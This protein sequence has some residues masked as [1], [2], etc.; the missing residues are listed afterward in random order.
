MTPALSDIIA[1]ARGKSPADLVLAN[2]R[3][4]N[5]FNGDIENGNVA[6][7]DGKIAGIGDYDKARTVIDLDGRYLAPGLINGHT[8]IESSMLDIGQY[9]NA[10]IPHGTLIVVT[11]LHEIA[12]VSGIAGLRYIINA[13][14]RLPFE[15]FLMAP[16]CVPA[17]QLETSGANIDSTALHNILHWK[18]VIGLGEM[19]NYPGVLSSNKEVLN[20]IS[21]SANKIVD[22]HAPDLNGHDL[23]AYIASGIS[24]DHESTTMAEAREKLARGIYIMIREGSSEKNLEALL[25]LVTDKTYKRCLFVVDDRN[26]SDL[27]HDGDV[28]AVVRKAIHLGLEPVR[29]IQMASINA[30]ERFG[31]KNMGA[32]APGYWADMIVVEDLHKF[33]IGMVFHHGKLVA[34]NG[35]PMFNSPVFKPHYLV[36]SIKVKPFNIDSLRIKSQPGACTV[37]EVIPR[38]IVTRKVREHLEADDNG[39]LQADTSRDILKL[40]VIERHKA[41]GNISKGFIKGFGLKN[42]ALASSIAHDSHNI[43]AVGTCDEDIDL[44]VKEIMNIKG[45][46]V[47]VSKGIVIA[48][49]PLPISGLLSDKALPE[50]VSMF[51]QVEKAAQK[52]GVTLWSPF[53]ALSFMALPVIPEIRLTDLGLVDVC[54]FEIIEH[55]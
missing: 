1:V 44:A 29:A 28:D 40:V 16:S 12:N 15:L 6:V 47:V 38:Q 43:I 5:V 48:T 2:A 34:K 11:D 55:Y 31:L 37:I 32:I 25:P 9:A 33:G 14:R 42:G 41:T 7:Y 26:C 36:D 27:L 19:M 35:M 18:H 52:L 24:S 4:V 51:E 8:H 50:V 10:V 53:A 3:I 49:L 45:G 20:K 13:S 46:L 23:N 17:T 21:R 30:A 54:K 39:F 22:G